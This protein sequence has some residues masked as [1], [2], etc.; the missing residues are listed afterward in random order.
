M[1]T[2][3]IHRMKPTPRQSFRW[4]AHTAGTA[5]VKPRDYEPDGEVEAASPYNAW[6]MLAGADRPLQV[7]DLLENPDGELRIC[8]YVGFEEA[9]WVLPEVKPGLPE[10]PHDPVHPA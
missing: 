1:P 10:D 4:A 9:R 8:K 3:R 2:Y 6:A 5:A 7:G